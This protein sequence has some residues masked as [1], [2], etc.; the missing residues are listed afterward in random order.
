MTLI[1][2]VGENRPDVAVKLDGG[3]LPTQRALAPEGPSPAAGAAPI[4][5]TITV[6]IQPTGVL[7][8][9]ACII[10]PIPVDA[11]SH[12]KPCRDVVTKESRPSRC[13]TLA[14]HRRRAR[15]RELG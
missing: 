13:T 8:C 15:W 4:A 14:H 5:I 6:A 10:I 2:L 3:R 1:T 7:P 12:C 11:A 9:K